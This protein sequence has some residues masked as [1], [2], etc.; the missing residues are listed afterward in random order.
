MKEEENGGKKEGL[1]ATWYGGIITV[2]KDK[3]KVIYVQP[4]SNGDILKLYEKP[5]AL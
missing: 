5:T 4:M 1:C 3:D 2:S